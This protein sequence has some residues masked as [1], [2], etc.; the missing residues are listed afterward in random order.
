MLS[1][2]KRFYASGYLFVDYREVCAVESEFQLEQVSDI[3]R[4]KEVLARLA[5]DD[6]PMGRF[7]WG[8]I[9]TLKD[10]PRE[11]GL[12]IRNELINFYNSEF[13]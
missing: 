10:G 7:V 9:S 12:N 4:A 2:K 3:R 1:G 5:G 6:H 8:N 11:K 13:N